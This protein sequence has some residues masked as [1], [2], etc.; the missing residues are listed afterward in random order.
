MRFLGYRAYGSGLT[1]GRDSA[2]T[3][4]RLG[5]RVRQGL[6]IRVKGLGGFRVWG[7]FRVEGVLQWFQVF[8][9]EG[10]GFRVVV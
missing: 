9:V 10:L 3:R 4:P 2:V 6:G 7:W 8:R 1:L 5:F